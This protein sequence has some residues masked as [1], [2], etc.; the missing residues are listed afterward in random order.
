[1]RFKGP[2]HINSN[3]LFALFLLGAILVGLLVGGKR[4]S[5]TA[6]VSELEPTN[7][8]MEV[9]KPR[10]QAVAGRTWRSVVDENSGIRLGTEGPPLMDPRMVKVS[11]TGDILILDWGGS[12]NQEIS[13]RQ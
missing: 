12:N 8:E 5:T 7:L 11:I 6:V 9:P 4:S 10:P 1:M 3:Y 13:R 2:R